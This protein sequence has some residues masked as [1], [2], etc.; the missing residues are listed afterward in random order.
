MQSSAYPR[1]TTAAPKRTGRLR[2]AALSSPGGFSGLPDAVLRELGKY[3][4]I[5]AVIDGLRIPLWVRLLTAARTFRPRRKDWARRYYSARG[6]YVKAIRSLLQRISRCERELASLQGSYDLIFQFGALFGALKR[7]DRCPL[8][9]QID[10]T[11]RLAE[12]YFPGWL[13]SSPSETLDWNNLEGELYRNA[14]L[15][16]VTNSLVQE[17]VVSHYGASAEKVAVV[18]MGAHIELLSE[19]FSKPQTRVLV[20]AG[21]DFD[22]HGGGVALEIF[23]G[24]RRHFS[25]ASFKL[26]TNR[27]VSAPGVEN[28][29]IIPHPRFAETLREASVAL[30]PAHVG[31]YQTITEAMAAKC[32]CVVASG[33]PHLHGLIRNGETG[34]TF[35]F[36]EP[37]TAVGQIVEY[38][39]EPSRLLA[40]GQQAREHVLRECTWPSVVARVW[41]E[42]QRRFNLA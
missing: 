35:P 14:D 9:M 37:D 30:M 36:T 13:P 15:I 8:V 7:P 42:L 1:G 31:G 26:L 17:S 34:L 20:F 21:H 5:V 6:R 4:E 33:N 38:L 39:R 23:Q 22:R 25:D 19:D 40:I 12:E 16:L 11:T 2:V 28:L 24:V 18:G 27:M 32:L 10:F 41:D 3:C 29:G